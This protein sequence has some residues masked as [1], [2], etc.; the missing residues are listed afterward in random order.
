MTKTEEDG[1]KEEDE[2]HSLVGSTA[3]E[4]K[5]DTTAVLVGFLLD[6]L[7]CTLGQ[8]SCRAKGERRGPRSLPF[9]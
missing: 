6:H 8:S 5:I 4:R 9:R 1:L 2:G 3:H 7:A